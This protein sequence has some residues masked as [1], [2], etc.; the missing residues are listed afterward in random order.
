MGRDWM[1]RPLRVS[2]DGHPVGIDPILDDED[3]IRQGCEF[4]GVSSG[5]AVEDLH[6]FG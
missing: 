5:L 2:V 1:A 3:L 6:M 4:G